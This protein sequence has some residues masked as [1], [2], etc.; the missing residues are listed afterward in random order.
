MENLLLPI[1]NTPVVKIKYM[2]K[3]KINYFYSKL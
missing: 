1:G 3:N 2:Y